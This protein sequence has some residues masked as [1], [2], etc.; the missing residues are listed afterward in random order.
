MASPFELEFGEFIQHQ[1]GVGGG[2]LGARE[3]DDEDSRLLIDSVTGKTKWWGGEAR[4][5]VGEERQACM[6]CAR[7]LLCA[8]PLL[9]SSLH[10]CRRKK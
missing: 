2:R 6:A 10:A 1:T 4:L 3:E 8:R 5:A 7:L 9:K